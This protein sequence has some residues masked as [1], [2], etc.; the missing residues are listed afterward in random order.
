MDI[1]NNVK[2]QKMVK[3]EFGTD[4]LGEADLIDDIFFMVNQYYPES[5]CE[6]GKICGIKLERYLTQKL[7]D[8]VHADPDPENKGTIKVADYGYIKIPTEGYWSI[9]ELQLTDSI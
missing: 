3:L 7:E 2:Q 1:A 6:D 9:V 4:R 5:L 8:L